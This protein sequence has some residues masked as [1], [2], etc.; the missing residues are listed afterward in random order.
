MVGKSMQPSF[1]MAAGQQTS[2]YS[3]IL[4][5][6]GRVR[7]VFSRRNCSAQLLIALAVT[8][9]LVSY[10]NYLKYLRQI[11]LGWQREL[12]QHLFV[13]QSFYYPNSST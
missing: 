7:S 3:C 13:Y 5:L 12:L 2:S 4:R 11:R 8:S 6:G 1:P 9:L 10:L